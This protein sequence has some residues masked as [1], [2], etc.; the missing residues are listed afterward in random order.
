MQIATLGERTAF[1]GLL[2]CVSGSLGVAQTTRLVME[3]SVDNAQSW[4]SEVEAQ[5]GDVVYF[6]LRA[7][8]IGATALGLSGLTLQPILTNFVGGTDDLEPFTVSGGGSVPSDPPTTTGVIQP[9]RFGGQAIDA[10]TGFVDP[11]NILR[12]A[13][14]KNTTPFLNLAWGVSLDQ[15]PAALS[16]TLFESSPDVVLFRYAVTLN[17]TQQE[18]VAWPTIDGGLVGGMVKWYLNSTGTSVLTSTDIELVPA[19]VVPGPSVVVMW[20]SGAALCVRRRRSTLR[21]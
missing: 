12:F 18:R 5:P 16:G 21:T 15:Y 7:Q 2:V 8:L 13:G 19:R 1:A 20:L 4:S 10:I 11:G 14:S 9:F 17:S 3:A 6:R